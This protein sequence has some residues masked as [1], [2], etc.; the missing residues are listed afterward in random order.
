MGRTEANI[1][2]NT[3]ERRNGD[4]RNQNLL[5]LRISSMSSKIKGVVREEKLRGGG[6]RSYEIV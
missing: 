6:G 1:S 5:Y 3:A 2:T 4:C